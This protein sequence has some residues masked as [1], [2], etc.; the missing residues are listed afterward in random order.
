[1]PI[2]LSGYLGILKAPMFLIQALLRADAW[3]KFWSNLDNF[4]SNITHFAKCQATL[5]RLLL[6]EIAIQI[7]RNSEVAIT[8]WVIFSGT[9]D[10]F[11]YS[12]KVKLFRFGALL[13]SVAMRTS[14]WLES[15]PGCA[16][17]QISFF[18]SALWP[19]GNYIFMTSRLIIFDSKNSR[20]VRVTILMSYRTGHTIF[21]AQ[22]WQAQFFIL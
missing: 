12:L 22:S 9:T 11:T 16:D 21:T 18:H 13:A 10:W 20:I 8:Y 17:F 3:V 5:K 15:F 4:W 19:D 14:W 1:M 7:W 2:V 6:L